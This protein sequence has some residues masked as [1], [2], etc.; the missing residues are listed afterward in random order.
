MTGKKTFYILRVPGHGK[1]PPTV[2]IRDEHFTL[3]AYFRE[4]RPDRALQRCGLLPFKDALMEIIA[5]L[6]QGKIVQIEIRQDGSL[7]RTDE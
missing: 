5:S 2:Q 3:I 6:P 4:D 7:H 1:I